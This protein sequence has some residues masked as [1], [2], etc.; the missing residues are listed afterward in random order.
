MKD[1]YTANEWYKLDFDETIL[2][3][4]KLLFEQWKCRD[5]DLKYECFGLEFFSIIFLISM[6]NCIKKCQENSIISKCSSKT[7]CRTILMTHRK[8]FSIEISTEM[9]VSMNSFN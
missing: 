4:E 8:Y 5:D 3:S 9:T 1:N 7:E 6:R 2:L